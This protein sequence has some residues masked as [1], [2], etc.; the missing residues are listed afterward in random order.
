MSIRNDKS[1]DIETLK[2]LSKLNWQEIYFLKGCVYISSSLK[3]TRHGTK[4]PRNYGE[5][6]TAK[7]I[8]INKILKPKFRGKITISYLT[9]N[10][11]KSCGRLEDLTRY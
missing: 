5:G 7:R 3:L 6:V 11:R 9:G 1:V 8:Q 2:F 4:S 10:Y